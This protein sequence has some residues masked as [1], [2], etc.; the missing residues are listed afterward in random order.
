MIK[1]FEELK[2]ELIKINNETILK[3]NLLFRE[4][5]AELKKQIE[6]LEELQKPTDEEM[7][8]YI[9]THNPEFE[10]NN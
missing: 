2:K 6:V 7:L 4:T 8:D 10:T 1:Q 3:I 9:E 5:E